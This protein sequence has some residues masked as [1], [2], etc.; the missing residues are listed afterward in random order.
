MK[1]LVTLVLVLFVAGCANI[2][3]LIPEKYD[4]IEFNRLAEI[5]VVARNPIANIP[6]WCHPTEL[7]LLNFHTSVLEVY[8]KNTLKPRIAEIYTEL[9]S[10]ASEL[11]H[12]EDPSEA[13]CKIKRQN[14]AELTDQ[15]LAVFGN[16]SKK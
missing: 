16:R 8:A 15:A 7:K 3:N 12:R 14:I 10:L 1:P 11:Y 6:V 13:Y 5:N 2:S 9:N 4:P